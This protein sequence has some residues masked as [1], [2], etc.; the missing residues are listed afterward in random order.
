MFVIEAIAIVIQYGC[1]NVSHW[2]F[3]FKYYE[4]SRHTPYVIDES[5]IPDKV[6]RSNKALNR[7][8][9][10]FN[11]LV[12]LLQGISTFM[13]NLTYFNQGKSVPIWN[14]TMNIIQYLTFLL[15]IISGIFF[16]FAIYKIKQ[17]ISKEEAK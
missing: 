1:F 12:P 7:C 13:N 5:E 2:I 15:Q 10:T 16:G 3:S 17:Q 4:I 11:I 8:F 14:I 6:I 9:L